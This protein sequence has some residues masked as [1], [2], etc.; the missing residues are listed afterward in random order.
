MLID[1][2]SASP[3]TLLAEVKQHNSRDAIIVMGIVDVY[4]PNDVQRDPF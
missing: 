2:K 3:D 1:V 4:F